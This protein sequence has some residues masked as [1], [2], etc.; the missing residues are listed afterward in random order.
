MGLDESVRPGRG[1]FRVFSCMPAR[2]NSAKQ[3]ITVIRTRFDEKTRE[4]R[5]AAGRV[6]GL[7]RLRLTARHL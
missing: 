7:R 1:G 2:G 5:H 6:I 3:K 4:I